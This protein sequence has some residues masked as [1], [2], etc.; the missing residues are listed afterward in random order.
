MKKLFFFVPIHFFLLTT[1]FSQARGGNPKFDAAENPYEKILKDTVTGKRT[2]KFLM[3]FTQ[4]EVLRDYFTASPCNEYAELN[5]TRI[6]QFGAFV[7]QF[8][9]GRTDAKQMA[10]AESDF[11]KRGVT[12]QVT[13]MEY[14][15]GYI[16]KQGIFS[17]DAKEPV[18]NLVCR[19]KGSVQAIKSILAYLEAVKKLFPSIDG[20]DDAIQK[21]KQALVA[22]PDN[23]ALL[24][25]IKKNKS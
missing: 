14:H 12:A 22:Y 9:S 6:T 25:I 7:E 10:K 13:E 4:P 8:I 2:A 3:N 18:E 16:E 17:A 21:G 11:K 24:A 1:V 19:A 20:I 23:K 5:N 15:I